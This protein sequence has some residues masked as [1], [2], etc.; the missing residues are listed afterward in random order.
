MDPAL[1]EVILYVLVAEQFL[2]VADDGVLIALP[3]PRGY[4]PPVEG[5]LDAS[6]LRLRIA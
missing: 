5:M 6:D 2:A 1:C 3:T 4:T